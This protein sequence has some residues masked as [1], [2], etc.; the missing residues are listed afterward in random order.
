MLSVQFE[1]AIYGEIREPREYKSFWAEITL[2]Q[3]VWL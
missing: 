1:I 2:V 3:V